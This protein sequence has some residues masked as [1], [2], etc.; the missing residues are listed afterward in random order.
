M[1][2]AE[3]GGALMAV[4]AATGTPLWSFQTNQMWRAS[5]MTYMFDGRQYIAIASGSQHPRVR[6]AEDDDMRI[7]LIMLLALVQ[8]N[9]PGAG[10]PTATI[11]NGP[12]QVTVYLPDAKAGYY[13]GTRFDWSGAVASLTFKGHEYFGQW[14]EQ[15][16]PFLHDGIPG[17]SRSS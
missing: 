11:A 9:A 2:V 13:R 10:A 15:H 17:R 12:L 14:F 5:P 8:A 16:D 7:L 4:D 1:I 6:G 3:E